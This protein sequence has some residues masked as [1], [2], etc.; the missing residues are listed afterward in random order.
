METWDTPPRQWYI[1]PTDVSKLLIP[2]TC[3]SMHTKDKTIGKSDII[4]KPEV[5]Y[6]TLVYITALWVVS[7]AP[8]QSQPDHLTWRSWWRKRDIYSRRRK[9]VSSSP[10]HFSFD[11]KTVASKFSGHGI[12][13]PP[14]CKPHK[15]PILVNHLL[16]ITLLSLHSCL[17]WDIKDYGTRALWSPFKDTKLFHKLR[18]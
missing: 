4:L 13:H 6:H 17:H 11:Y 9:K 16:S 7:I 1:L 14:A 8:W 18:E 15:G 5:L 12:S 3:S 10:P 2:R